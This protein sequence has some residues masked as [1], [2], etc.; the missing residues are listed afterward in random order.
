LKTKEDNKQGKR[1]GKELQKQ[2]K[3]IFKMAVMN[4][5]NNYLE[6]KLVKFSSQKILNVAEWVCLKR[7]HCVLSLRDSGMEK[8]APCMRSSK[9]EE[10]TILTS[11]KTDFK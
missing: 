3:I 9:E 11:D 10:A 8:N 6:C 7:S 5:V 4:P 1:G 2:P